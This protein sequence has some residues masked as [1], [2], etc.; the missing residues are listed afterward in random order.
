MT[1]PEI[2]EK[3][4][5]PMGTIKTRLRRGLIEVRDKLRHLEGAE[6]PISSSP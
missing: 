3:T 1:H 6:Q 4:S 2:S 5:L